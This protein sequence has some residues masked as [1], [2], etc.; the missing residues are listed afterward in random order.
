MNQSRDDGTTAE[1]RRLA[2]APDAPKNSG[3]RLLSIMAA[4]MK[5]AYP[6]LKRLISYQACDIHK[7]TIYK[8]A[9]WKPSEVIPFSPWGTRKR[10]RP[11]GWRQREYAKF[12]H[13]LTPSTR[14]PPQITSDKIRWELK[15]K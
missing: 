8:A 6:S 9:G 14:K 2:I 12:G 7:G 1:L 4:M 5:A 15:L 3:S 11:R 10:R 13:V